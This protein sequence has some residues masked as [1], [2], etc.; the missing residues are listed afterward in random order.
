MST[1]ADIG[2]AVI[3]DFA[4]DDYQ[5][6]EA[7][8][9]GGQSTLTGEPTVVTVANEDLR[10][11]TTVT[12]VGTQRLTV[13]ASARGETTVEG[14]VTLPQ[15]VRTDEGVVRGERTG[16]PED[17][18]YPFT[19]DSTGDIQTVS[20]EDFYEQH[21]LL[22]GAGVLETEIGGPLTANDRTEITH[23]IE[24]AYAESPYFEPPIR[25]NVVEQVDDT[26]TVQATFGSREEVRIPISQRDVDTI[27][28]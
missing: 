19:F 1:L 7:G 18:A 4:I 3:G 28:L 10:G 13:S 17:T 12:A 16:V 27:Q 22:L 11:D 14:A 26:L 9:V 21:A 20:G 2:E 5:I 25:V 24:Q 6:L 15:P 8:D 23:T